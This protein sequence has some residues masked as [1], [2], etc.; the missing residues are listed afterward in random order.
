MKSHDGLVNEMKTKESSRKTE[1]EAKERLLRERQVA[2]IEQLKSLSRE[3]NRARKSGI[4]KRMQ[5]EYVD[6]LMRAGTKLKSKCKVL[7]EERLNKPEP[8]IEQ[9]HEEGSEDKKDL[10]GNR[11][12]S[13]DL[14]FA[15]MDDKEFEKMIR[16]L[17]AKASKGKRTVFDT[18]EDISASETG[19]S[20]KDEVIPVQVCQDQIGE[21]ERDY[22]EQKISRFASSA[23][24]AKIL[25]EMSD[26][27]IDSYQSRKDDVKSGSSKIEC[28]RDS[29]INQSLRFPYER[30]EAGEIPF[31]DR[32]SSS[33]IGRFRVRDA[34]EFHTDSLRRIPVFFET[35]SSPEGVLLLVGKDTN[36][37]TSEDRDV[38]L[39]LFCTIFMTY[40]YCL[41]NA[42][43]IRVYIL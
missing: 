30:Y 4:D 35:K 6:K 5:A 41:T 8:T 43:Y 1:K 25:A 42:F 14:S 39:L 11:S 29:F 2:E 9:Q 36:K 24:Q 27:N 7:P 18:N 22:E 3:K 33:E 32:S 12:G 28:E 21:N 13:K 40:N 17:K 19:L 26:V 20:N 23:A 15:D 10:K 34:R 38:W 37:Q 16:K 31:F